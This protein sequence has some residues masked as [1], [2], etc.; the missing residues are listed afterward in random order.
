MENEIKKKLYELKEQMEETASGY[1]LDF[2]SDYEAD[3]SSYLSDAFHEFADN[4]ISVYYS[5]QFKY[6][7]E[8]QSECED[9]LLELCDGETIMEKI[10]H[11]GLYNVCCYAGVCG[12]YNKITSDL[13]EDE[14]IIKKLLVIRYLLKYDIFTMTA[15]QVAEMLEEVEAA[16]INKIDELKDIMD[17]YIEK[18]GE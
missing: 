14:E 17:T 15:E 13:Y 5:D 4:N 18:E 2:V 12:E 7:E 8:N 16:N 10:K 9:A 1:S 11:E 3:S 6:Y